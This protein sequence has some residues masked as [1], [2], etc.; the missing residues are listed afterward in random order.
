MDILCIS[1]TDWDEIWGSR[2]QIML[3]FAGSGHRVL[4][5]ERQV[6]IEHLFRDPVLFRRKLTR[7]RDAPLKESSP[8]LWIWHPSLMIPGRYYSMLLNHLGQ[9]LLV[10]QVL[11]ILQALEFSQ[12]I[13]WL[14]PPHSAPLLHRFN[15]SCSIYHCIDRFAGNQIGLK[16]TIIENQEKRLLQNVDIVFTHSKGLQEKYACYTQRPIKLIPSAADI[17]HFQSTSEIH[18]DI[19]LIPHP[20][21]GIMGTFDGRLDTELLETLITQYPEWHFVFIGQIR[22]GRTDLDRLLQ[23]QNVHYLGARPYQELPMLLNG[24]DIFLIPY[25]LNELTQFI[26]PLKLYEY[27]AVGKPIISVPLPEVMALSPH[28]NIADRSN[29]ADLILRAL[30]SDTPESQQTRREAAKQHNWDDRIQEIQLTIN[31][32]FSRECI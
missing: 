7:W 2:Q 9:H 13:L 22:P 21:I 27:L 32:F 29:F 31:E 23:W 4:F 8:N 16:H 5:I 19:Q 3:R 12:P 15:E 18:Q 30:V 10:T 6:S 28:V 17:A 20:R 24:M 14:Y 25:R 1:T 11:P 26:N